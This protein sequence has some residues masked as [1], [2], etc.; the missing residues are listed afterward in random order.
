MRDALSGYFNITVLIITII[1]ATALIA[2]AL[3]Y[4]RAYRV[5]DFILT[6]I[7]KYE[8]NVDNT[9]MLSHIQDYL[10]SV[11]YMADDADMNKAL[12][13][14]NFDAC[15]E[16]QGTRQGWCY[17]IRKSNSK[18]DEEY[19]DIVVFV[20][21]RVPFIRQLFSQMGAFQMRGS[22]SAIPILDDD[23]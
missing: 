13:Q 17:K 2:L 19:V 15:P 21:L 16:Y 3:N 1:I 18:K 10:A 4:T 6:D 23:E 9:D 22:T 8:G 7:E 14:N 5:K 11:G 12:S 20:N